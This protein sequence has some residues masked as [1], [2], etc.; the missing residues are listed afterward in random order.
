LRWL[1]FSGSIPTFAGCGVHEAEGHFYLVR[2]L[3]EEL[4]WWL[5]M[6]ALLRL[7]G[8]QAPSRAAVEELSKTVATALASAEAAGY[9]IDTLLGSLASAETGESGETTESPVPESESTEPGE[10]PA[11]APNSQT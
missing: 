2:E 4:L 7:A 6:P 9:R 5:L 11:S 10:N 1:P 3:Y 8:E